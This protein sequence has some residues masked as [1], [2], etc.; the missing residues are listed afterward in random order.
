MNRRI[1]FFL[2]ILMAEALLPIG[3]FAAILS[4]VNISKKKEGWY[5]TGLP[6]VNYSSDDGFGYGARAY[7]FYNGYHDDKYYEK[8]E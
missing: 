3:L 7:L 8:T 6:L 5:P 2:C 1:I 4:D